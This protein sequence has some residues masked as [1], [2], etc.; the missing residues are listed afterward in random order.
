MCVIF[1]IAT[2]HKKCALNRSVKK[3]RAEKNGKEITKSTRIKHQLNQR[4]MNCNLTGNTCFAHTGVLPPVEP[5]CMR[6]TL[7]IY[8][9]DHVA[10]VATVGEC[11]TCQ[12]R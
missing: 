10:T 12:A 5:W 2:A 7:F 4:G 6:A 8:A 3:E 1:F 11:G 9:P